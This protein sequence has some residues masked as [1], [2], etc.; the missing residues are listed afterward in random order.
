MNEEKKW[1]NITGDLLK[2]LEEAQ[3]LDLDSADAGPY[4][5]TYEYGGY[6]SIICC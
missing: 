6:L 2:E 1:E 4:S 5:I 3:K